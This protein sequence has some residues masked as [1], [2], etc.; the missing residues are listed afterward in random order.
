LSRLS[1]RNVL[2][3]L[4]P[5]AHSTYSIFT[6]FFGRIPKSPFF[7]SP[8]VHLFDPLFFLYVVVHFLTPDLRLLFLQPMVAAL[9]FPSIDLFRIRCKSSPRAGLRDELLSLKDG[10]SR[11]RSPP[12]APLPSWIPLPTRV[13]AFYRHCSPSPQ[14]PFGPVGPRC[15]PQT[16]STIFAGA[17]FSP[18]SVPGVSLATPPPFLNFLPSCRLAL[19]FLAPPRSID[20]WPCSSYKGRPD[21]FFPPSPVSK[22]NLGLIRPPPLFFYCCFVPDPPLFFLLPLAGRPANSCCLCFFLLSFWNTPGFRFPSLFLGLS[23]GPCKSPLVPQ[24]VCA[25]LSTPVRLFLEV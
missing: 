12:K 1:P 16:S 7:L 6:F 14:F 15:C 19:F 22:R 24:K 3:A 25:V 4:P 9:F 11:L 23:Y 8:P 5:K 2:P 21:A 13:T 17:K 10:P 18:L 20:F